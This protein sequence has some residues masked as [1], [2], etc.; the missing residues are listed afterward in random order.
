MEKL[1]SISSKWFKW[2]EF[3]DSSTARRLKID[4]TPRDPLVIINLKVLSVDLSFIRERFGAPIIVNSGYR[5]PSL[6][7]AVGGVPKSRHQDGLAADI[8]CLT[9][10]QTYELFKFLKTAKYPFV[11]KVIWEQGPRPW[12][13]FEIK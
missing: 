13:H 7:K 10:G 2:H 8:R 1:S 4:N 9:L 5:C 6:N 12:I 3:I 11:R